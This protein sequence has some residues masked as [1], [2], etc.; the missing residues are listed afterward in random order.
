MKKKSVCLKTRKREGEKTLNLADKIGLIN[1]D[2]EIQRDTEFIFI[3]LNRRPSP[4]ELKNLKKIPQ[5][6]VSE[7]SFP[8]RKRPKKSLV[9]LV[10]YELPPHLLAN[11]PHAVDFVGDVAIV[12]ISPELD[13]YKLAIGE[14]ILRTNPRIR[15]VLSKVGAVG[16][17][18][19][20]REFSVIAGQ[21]KTE[22]VHKEY[23]C[24]YYVDVAKA[25]FSPRLSFEHHR[26][27]SLV[28]DG[29]TVVDLFSGVGPFSVQTAKN[30]QEVTIYA[31]DINP[32]AVEYLK[33][34]I[35]INRVI[36]AV[37]P[38]V[39]DARQVTQNMLSDVADRVIMN[40]PEKAIQFVDVACKAMKPSG[41]I[42]HFYSF[43]NKSDSLENL[44]VRFTESVQKS[45][46][47][48][49]KI[50]FSRLVRETA[51]NQWQAVLDA[52]IC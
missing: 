41:G 35:R 39:G 8:Q 27:A 17:T 29:E 10:E 23:G 37:H 19:R 45:R 11:L 1:R 9:E 38:I 32:D 52:R 48:V 13:A 47:T 30:H 40:L 6:E 12:E 2:L 50:L 51:P 28:Q 46:R 16:G 24:Q 43:I 3:P 42:V 22:T 7:Y 5:L 34:N 36:G 26:V 4:E 25:F 31:I 44:T 18:Y 21:H 33:K 14:A 20:L 49:E 15:T